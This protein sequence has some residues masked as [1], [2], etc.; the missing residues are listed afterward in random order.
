MPPTVLAGCDVLLYSSRPQEKWQRPPG[1]PVDARLYLASG[2]LLLN[3]TRRT[4]QL[5]RAWAEAMA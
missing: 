1:S 3:Q 2:V 5:L 4:A